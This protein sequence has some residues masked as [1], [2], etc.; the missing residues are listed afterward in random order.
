MGMSS[1]T[2]AQADPELMME[3]KAKR[4]FHAFLLHGRDWL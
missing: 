4:I 3:E 2:R 1:I